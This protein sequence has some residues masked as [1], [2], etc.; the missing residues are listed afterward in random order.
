MSTALFRDGH[1]R[2]AVQKAAERFNARVADLSER[3]DLTGGS[4]I[5][6]AFSETHPLLVFS[7]TRV[8]LLERDWHN[9]YRFLALGWPLG[10]RNIYTHD[11]DIEVSRTEAVEWLA[12]ISGMHRRLDR[13]TQTREREPATDEPV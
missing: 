9:G 8:T 7:E 1:Y 5:N 11:L 13:T 12:F 2:E 4:L 3:H 10:I 6:N